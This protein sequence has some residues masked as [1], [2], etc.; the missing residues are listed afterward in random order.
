MDIYW[1]GLSCFRL[2]ERNKAAIITDPFSEGF[3][4]T[5][6]KLDADVVTVSHDAPGHNNPKMAK[7]LNPNHLLTGP[8]EYEIGG[9]FITGIV[10][11]DRKRREQGD[12]NVIY[13][14]DFENVTVAHL[15]DLHFVPSQATMESLSGV[16]VALVPVGGGKGLNAAQAA[17][18]VSLLEPR[19]VIPMHYHTPELEGVALDPLDKFL[20]EM[21]V[22]H[23]EPIESL[24]LTSHVTEDDTKVVVLGLKA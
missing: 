13:H 22:T 18:V 21:G 11:A 10:P 4:Y 6:K 7:G 5:V 24:R 1:Y 2:V 9:V 14:F 12:R 8:G 20:H 23:V 19:L 17:E 3:G 15:G 16:D